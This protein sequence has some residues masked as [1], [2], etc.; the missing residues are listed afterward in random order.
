MYLL[1][2][3]VR[4]V[5]EN[6]QTV[7]ITDPE[8]LANFYGKENPPRVKYIREKKHLAYGKAHEDEY[9]IELLEERKNE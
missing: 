1:F 5:S 9:S 7:A 3:A 2:K 6:V 8:R 4:S